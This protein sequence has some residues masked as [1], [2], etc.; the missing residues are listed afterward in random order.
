M[1]QSVAIE[2]A[3]GLLG[4]HSDARLQ[5]LADHSFLNYHAPGMDY[6]CLHRS[7]DLT[8]KIYFIDPSRLQT[9]G[10]RDYLVSPHDHAYSFDTVVLRGHVTNVNFAASPSV[11]GSRYDPIVTNEWRYRAS[12]R[13]FEQTHRVNL[14]ETSRDYLNVGEAYHLSSTAVH[15]IV[16]PGGL[17]TA[18]LLFQQRDVKTETRFF[19]LDAPDLDGLY[20]RP[21]IGQ[22]GRLY[23]TA[24]ELLFQ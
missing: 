1:T 18:L 21:S 9:C 11:P 6:L 20:Q 4:S 13:H 17:P 14:W 19:G 8:V 3:R 5:R 15:T 2:V 10:V 7:D 12:D 23:S 24:L 16:V 22:V